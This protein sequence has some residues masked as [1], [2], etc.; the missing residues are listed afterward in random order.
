MLDMGEPVRILELARLMIRQAGLKVKD[1]EHPDGD[2]EIQFSGLRPGEKLHEELLIGDSTFPTEHPKILRGQEG[3]LPWSQVEELV[4]QFEGV[5]DSGRIK[6]LLL[7]AHCGY[8]PQPE[9]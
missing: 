7:E 1:L 6:A 8:Q 9:Q 4:Q 5:S 3:R 2:I